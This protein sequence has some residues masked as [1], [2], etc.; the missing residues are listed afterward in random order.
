MNVNHQNRSYCVTLRSFAG[1]H[2]GTQS[3]L[4][5]PRMLGRGRFAMPGRERYARTA[6]PPFPTPPLRDDNPSITSL[7]NLTE[8]LFPRLLMAFELCQQ[9][10]SH[11]LQAGQFLFNEMKL[12]VY[13]F[14]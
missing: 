12:F 1:D 6:S 7:W 14:V 9:R 11:L 5:I 3:S 4:G 2:S 10:S 13:E 8:Q